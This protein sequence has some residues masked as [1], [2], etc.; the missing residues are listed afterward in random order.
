[1]HEDDET[2]PA[3]LRLQHVRDHRGD[4]A[5]DQHQR[6]IRDLRQFR[7]DPRA[8]SPVDIRPPTGG[9]MLVDRPAEGVEPVAHPAVVH[10]ATARPSRIIDPVRDHD[11]HFV[12]SARS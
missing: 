6:V 4:E 12:H 2:Q 5:V 1:M 3:G 11:V 7:S 10:V 8:G 9:G